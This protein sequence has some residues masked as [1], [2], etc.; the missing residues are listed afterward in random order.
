MLQLLI[1]AMG[2]TAVATIQPRRADEKRINRQKALRVAQ[3]KRYAV[4]ATVAPISV[5]AVTRV[6]SGTRKALV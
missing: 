2:I 5:V 1:C 6:L 3:R 4:S